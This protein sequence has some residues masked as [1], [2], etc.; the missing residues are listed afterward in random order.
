MLQ[1]IKINILSSYFKLKVYLLKVRK[2]IVWVVIVT[3]PAHQTRGKNKNSSHFMK[4]LAI[5]QWQNDGETRLDVHE[6]VGTSER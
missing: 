3:D 2:N 1:S 4:W 6:W 5:C